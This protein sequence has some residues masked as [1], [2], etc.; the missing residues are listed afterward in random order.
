MKENLEEVK[1][2]ARDLRN[3]RE[4]T[5]YAYRVFGLHTRLILT[6]PMLA[7]LIYP[8]LLGRWT[9]GIDTDFFF[10]SGGKASAAVFRCSRR[11][12]SPLRTRRSR[13]IRKRTGTSRRIAWRRSSRTKTRWTTRCT[14]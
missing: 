5:Q 14:T 6:A 12:S 7:A 2:L 10:A 13:R 8:I 4:F 9:I 1:P 3:G 11:S